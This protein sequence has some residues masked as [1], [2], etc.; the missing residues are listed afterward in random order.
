MSVKICYIVSDIDKALSLEWICKRLNRDRIRLS[1]IVLGKNADSE[2]MA[3]LKK[4]QVPHIF[5]RYESKKDLPR[6]WWNVFKVL[7]RERPQGVHTHL[8]TAT[9]VG[10]TTAWFLGIPK[11]IHTRHHGSI[12][13]EYFPGTV[14]V[15]KLMN[16]LSTD[17]ITLSSALSTIVRDW[18]GADP[19]KIRLIPHGF[20]LAYF[21][22]ADLA[23]VARLRQRYSIGESKHPVIGV[24]ARYTEWKGIQFI[25]P[26]FKRL[27]DQFPNAHLVLANASGDYAHEIKTL[28]QTLPQ[29]SYTEIG[30]EG[31]V[32]SLYRLF[33]VFVHAPVDPYCEAFGQT[34]VEAL[35]ACVP[36]VFTRSGIAADFIVD[37]ENAIVVAFKDSTA[38]ADGMMR[39]LAD[40]DLRSQLAANGR[41]SVQKL[42]DLSSMIERLETL[43]E[44]K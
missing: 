37:G 4:E 31:E 36:S 11:R 38:I 25:I 17:I 23:T 7:R 2:L 27:L 13:H 41:E 44:K 6:I 30:F 10:L 5:I 1:F 22:H 20:D 12:H 18:E 16:A 35:A 32:A 14:M 34:Y 3:F 33:D 8:F 19:N 39:I 28:L 43:Y 29:S 26:A 40:A 24:I 42:F 9:L 21:T 15:D